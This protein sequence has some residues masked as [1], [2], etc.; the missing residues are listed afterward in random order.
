MIKQIREKKM[1]GSMNYEEKFKQSIGLKEPWHVER[2]EYNIIKNNE[3]Y[4]GSNQ[5]L[6]DIYSNYKISLD[7]ARSLYESYLMQYNFIKKQYDE[8]LQLVKFEKV[9]EA[10]FAKN[11]SFADVQSITLTLLIQINEAVSSYEE[12]VL[13]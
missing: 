13:N 7:K 11:S 12:D 9:E 10:L 5:S 1:N 3:E 4:I 2:A 8:N 6:K